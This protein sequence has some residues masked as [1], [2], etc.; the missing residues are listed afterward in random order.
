[1]R[2]ALIRRAMR[3]LGKTVAL[4]LNGFDADSH[5]H[6]KEIVLAP[7]SDIVAPFVHAVVHAYQRPLP[8]SCHPLYA[9]DGGGFTRYT[10]S[11]SDPAILTNFSDSG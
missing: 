8:T 5:Y 3:R 11:V 10:D 2:Y 7:A 1:M 4:I 6:C 9:A